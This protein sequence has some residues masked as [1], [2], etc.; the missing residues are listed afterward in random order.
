MLL[1][2][3][4]LLLLLLLL[5]IMMMLVQQSIM[6]VGSSTVGG[7]G[8]V[9]R[10]IMCTPAPIVNRPEYVYAR[11]Y[12]KV[13]LDLMYCESICDGVAVSRF[14][15]THPS[16][17]VVPHGLLYIANTFSTPILLLQFDLVACM[18]APSE[19]GNSPEKLFDFYYVYWAF[20][21]PTSHKTSIAQSSCIV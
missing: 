3:A 9:N 10:N 13:R 21:L 19:L 2:A 16:P 20:C 4:S 15:Y 18:R 14:I 5:M 6:Q 11:Q 7:C 17:P 8:D 1:C 12:T